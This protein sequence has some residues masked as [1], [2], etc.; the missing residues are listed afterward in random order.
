V[1]ASDASSRAAWV[2]AARPEP[3]SLAL[4][5]LGQAGFALCGDD[6]TLLI[7]A[8][9]AAQ[10]DRLVPPFDRPE[11]FD[12]LDGVLATHEHWD[13]LDLAV[14]PALAAAS[15]G[16]RFVVPGPVV[17][18]VVAA[19]LSAERVFGAAP[20]EPF[21][22]GG[23]R[24]VP[25]PARHGLHAADAYTFGQE[26]SGGAYRYLGYVV[27][28]NGVRVYHAGDT[29]VYDGLAER[30]RRL[31]VDL[32][33]L[34]INGRDHYREQQDIVGNLSYREA[35]D[36]AAEGGVDLVVPMHYEMFAA[37]QERP[38]V[39]LD[40]L[41]QTHPGLNALAPGRYGGFVYRPPRA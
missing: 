35:A 15:P 3:G 1:P 28:L 25:V 8:F 31:R 37:N 13:H 22:I 33:L 32:A 10:P 7:D 4:F 18:Q 26:L 38:G 29:I 14:W 2:R 40:Y 19:G 17:P 36:L 12:F 34:P 16:A 9:L 6:T 20:D 39:F 24:I 21:T 11:R 27:E 5:W 30:L 23:A 41:R